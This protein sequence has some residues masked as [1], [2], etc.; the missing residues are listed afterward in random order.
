MGCGQHFYR[1]VTVESYTVSWDEPFSHQPDPDGFISSYGSDFS[2][3]LDQ[4]PAASQV[5]SKNDEES[6]RRRCYL[7]SSLG[8]K[9][10]CQP[11]GTSLGIYYPIIRHKRSEKHEHGSK[12]P[13]VRFFF[14]IFLWRSLPRSKEARK[15]VKSSVEHDGHAVVYFKFFCCPLYRS[16]LQ[17]TSVYQVGFF[18]SCWWSPTWL[19]RWYMII[20]DLSSNGLTFNIDGMLGWTLVPDI[21]FCLVYVLLKHFDSP[22][23]HSCVSFF[24]LTV[25]VDSPSLPLTIFDCQHRQKEVG[26]RKQSKNVRIVRTLGFCS[27]SQRWLAY[28]WHFWM[29]YLTH[30]HTNIDGIV[31]ICFVIG[32]NNN[33]RRV[34]LV[35]QI[36]QRSFPPTFSRLGLSEGLGG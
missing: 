35:T 14:G 2:F 30:K 22:D 15:L 36:S 24:Y 34:Y 9:S 25:L 21:P 20:R 8:I 33:K 11:Q 31:G 6:R 7:H 4:S 5:K 1:L 29:V 32:K 23:R 19:H 12:D 13:F 26:F 3:L 17:Y 27:M 28:F 16:W 10:W 18:T